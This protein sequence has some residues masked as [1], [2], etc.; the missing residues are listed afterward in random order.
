[1]ETQ[2][3]KF[4]ISGNDIKEYSIIY[5]S[6]PVAERIDYSE[7]ALEW[8][9]MISDATG[10]TLPVADDT[11]PVNEK[12]ILVGDTNR[13]ES[14]YVSPLYY[15]LTVNESKLVASSGGVYSQKKTHRAIQTNL[16]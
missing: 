15:V 4:T 10:V 6:V 3:R 13:E 12:E 2:I 11:T 1:M 16:Y 14:K 9:K 8:Q 5:P 7:L